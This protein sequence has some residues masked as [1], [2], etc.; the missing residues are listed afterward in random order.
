MEYKTIENI[1]VTNKT[2]LLRADL[3]VPVIEGKVSDTSRIDRLKKT[4]TFL[5]EKNAKTLILSHYGRPKGEKNPDYSLSFLPSTLEKC[6]DLPVRFIEDCSEDLVK[7]ALSSMEDGD[8]ALIENTRFYKEEEAND[9]SF[10][11]K[12]ASFGDIFVHD[13]FSTSHRAHAST[14]GIAHF[15]PTVAGFLMAE[16]LNA[17]SSSLN[18]PNRPLA[19][20]VGGSKISTKL[21][22]LENLIEK[23]DF[24]ILGGAMANTF[25]AARGADVKKS[26]FEE[27]M[28]GTALQILEL[29]ENSNCEIILPVDGLAAL[30]FK[31]NTSYQV[32]DVLSIPDDHMVLDIGPQTIELINACLL[33]CSTLVWNGPVGAFEISPFD[34]GTTAIARHVAILTE[35]KALKSVAGGGDTVSALNKA[36]VIEKMSYISTAGGAFLEWLEGKTLPG[37]AALKMY[38][39]AA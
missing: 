28:L 13:A 12:L 23:T 33:N 3:N 20:I 19:A 32:C 8:V 16:E 36:G 5:H 22:L 4:I 38:E 2:V 35:S 31:E 37:V 6:W 9:T 11:K 29:S 10:S 7:T 26:L 1:N 21:E 30:E 14:E 15:L 34:K 27:N 39:D 17:L 25:L 18:N 24:L